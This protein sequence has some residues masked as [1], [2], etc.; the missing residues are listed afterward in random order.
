MQSGTTQFLHVGGVLSDPKAW[1]LCQIEYRRTAIKGEMRTETRALMTVPEW[2]LRK[3]WE[4]LRRRQ[5]HPNFVKLWW[6]C[7]E[8]Y[9]ELL[10]CETW[11]S[12]TRVYTISCDCVNSLRGEAYHQI[13]LVED[14]IWQDQLHQ[15]GEQWHTHADLQVLS[16]RR[17]RGGAELAQQPEQDQDR[18]L[19]DRQPHGLPAHGPRIG[20]RKPAEPS[21]A[22]GVQGR[23]GL[24]HIV[25]AGVPAPHQRHQPRR[26]QPQTVTKKIEISRP[27]GPWYSGHRIWDHIQIYRKLCHFDRYGLNDGIEPFEIVM[28]KCGL[29]C[30][31]KKVMFWNVPTGRYVWGGWYIYRIFHGV[32]SQQNVPTPEIRTYW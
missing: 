28:R 17:G 30:V 27:N 9:G 16:V 7:S 10:T 29:G 11:D 3:S 8:V 14:L 20:R 21:D 15:H 13:Y 1:R 18:P 2:Y 23:R 24:T 26:G 32:I 25:S 5:W 4:N 19:Y 6:D 22:N 12:V 31:T